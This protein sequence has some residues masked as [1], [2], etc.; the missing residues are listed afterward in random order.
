MKSIKR[1]FIIVGIL[2]FCTLQHLQAQKLGREVLKDIVKSIPA[3]LEATFLIKDLAIPYN[4]TYLNDPAKV[5]GYKTEVKQALNLGIYVTNLEYAH[6]YGKK[7]ASKAAFRASKQLAQS[8]SIGQ[9][10]DEEQWTKTV[11]EN[12][13]LDSL[14]LYANKRT[15]QINDEWSK[16][17]KGHLMITM[18]TSGWIEALYLTTS[19]A[20][21]YPQKQLKNRVGEQKIILEQLLLLLS[22]YEAD[23]QVEAL[24][25]D[26][27]KLQKVY[28]NVKINFTYTKKKTKNGSVEV[29]DEN[30]STEIILT[31]KNLKSI[32]TITSAIRAKIIAKE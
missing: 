19:M 24:I 28:D 2:V 4:S 10:F 15:E 21:K 29:I 6:L 5:S 16:K 18:L 30:T 31:P 23:K 13:K 20:I 32:L 14:L 11:F 7:K 9:F 17:E 8:L 26:L 22:F 1:I 3:P 25:Q 12:N 27:N